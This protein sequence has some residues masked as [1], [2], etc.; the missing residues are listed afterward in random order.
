MS[1]PVVALTKA[2]ESWLKA[3]QFSLPI[4]V[5]RQ[6]TTGVTLARLE[7]L[8]TSAL[9]TIVPRAEGAIQ[10]VSQKHVA[11]ELLVD[12]CVR[13]KLGPVA[14]QEDSIATDAE[15]GQIDD[16][17]DLVE[18]IKLALMTMPKP[19][20][21]SYSKPPAAVNEPLLFDMEHV[22]KLRVFVSL[23]TVSFGVGR[24]VA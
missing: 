12:V 17:M 10:R 19:D 7:S 9:A 23:V 13:K 6:Y 4:T 5:E 15:I 22:E 20:G 24:V 3:A 18:E 2:V 14:R 8:Q 21:V 11:G 16:C 1:A